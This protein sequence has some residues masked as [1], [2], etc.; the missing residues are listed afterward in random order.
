M[1]ATTNNDWRKLAAVLYRKPRDSKIFGSVE[2]DVT[3][4][5]TYIQ[6]KRREGLKIT[7]THIFLLTVARC[8]WEETPELNCYV[9]RGAIRSRPGVDASLSVLV[10]L[11]MNSVLVKGAHQ[12]TLAELSQFLQTEVRNARKG[13]EVGAAKAKHSISRI[14]WPLRQWLMDLV[15]W[16]SI[17]WGIPLGFLGVSPDSFGSFILSNLGSIGLDVGYPAL[18]PFSRGAMVL[19]QGQV[20]DK[21]AVVD[22]QVL[23]RRIIT[24]SAALDH[25][26]VDAAQAGIL[27]TYIRRVLKNPEVLEQKP[28]W[29]S[30]TFN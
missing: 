1:D 9:Q 8:L 21:P 5:E 6:S 29:T 27:F 13:M 28:A 19:C 24:L 7:L 22:G 2:L 11:Q 18:A 16:L 10:G 3:D 26:L 20:M 4:V 17:K 12:M 23:P 25:R 14:P 30:A 15:L